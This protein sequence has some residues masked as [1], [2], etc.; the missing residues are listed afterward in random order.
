MKKERKTSFHNDIADDELEQARP[1]VIV[2]ARPGAHCSQIENQS[3]SPLI[4]LLPIFPV[5]LPNRKPIA[6]FSDRRLS[7]TLGEAVM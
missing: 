6:C 2:M 7:R 4:L 3:L 5:M 1:H